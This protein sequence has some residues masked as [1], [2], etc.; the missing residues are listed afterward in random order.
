MAWMFVV[1]GANLLIE[2][3]HACKVSEKIDSEPRIKDLESKLKKIDKDL[4]LRVAPDV[5]ISSVNVII[6][7][8]I[9]QG[10]HISQ[11]QTSVCPLWNTDVVRKKLAPFVDETKKILGDIG[12]P[13]ENIQE[14]WGVV[15]NV[16]D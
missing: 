16:F 9:L 8:E 1:N 10:R 15:V 4:I 3:V 5:E 7:K 12:I 14:S 11:Y 13:A 6:G 2:E